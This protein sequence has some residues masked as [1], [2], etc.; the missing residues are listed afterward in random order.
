MRAASG[1]CSSKAKQGSR[2]LGRQWLCR[3]QTV[4][5]VDQGGDRNRRRRHWRHEQ[6]RRKQKRQWLRALAMARA[7]SA[8]A[9]V[10]GEGKDMK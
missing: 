8:V 9:Q 10:A 7:G 5:G 3:R 2:T 1:G 4:A 6:G